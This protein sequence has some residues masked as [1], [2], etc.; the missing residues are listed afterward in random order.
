[1]RGPI[2]G[3]AA[4]IV[5]MARHA[6]A[7]EDWPLPDADSEDTFNVLPGHECNPALKTHQRR[8]FEVVGPG[9]GELGIA[10]RRDAR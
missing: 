6:C 8:G 9:R 5:E 1:M 4:F 10:M 3:A 2:I 7:M